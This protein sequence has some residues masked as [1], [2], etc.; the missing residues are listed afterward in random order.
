VERKYPPS[1][2]ADDWALRY[3]ASCLPND[4]NERLAKWGWNFTMRS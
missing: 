3:P 2:T 4:P 1:G